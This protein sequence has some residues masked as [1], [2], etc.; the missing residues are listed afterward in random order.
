MVIFVFFCNLRMFL[1][2]A[3]EVVY[4]LDG[5]NASVVLHGNYFVVLF[6]T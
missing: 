2:Q 5:K 4:L 3:A 6:Y 1:K